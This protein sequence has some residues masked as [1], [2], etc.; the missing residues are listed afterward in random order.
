M[1]QLDFLYKRTFST[2]CTRLADDTSGS[3]VPYLW[4]PNP[5]EHDEISAAVQLTNHDH[6]DRVD[7][8][9]RNDGNQTQEIKVFFMQKFLMMN[10][11]L[12]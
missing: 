6:F 9:C 10:A 8:F 12:I 2:K 7:V 4:R 5:L 11:Q 3:I 1:D